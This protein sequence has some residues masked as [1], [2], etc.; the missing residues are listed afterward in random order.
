MFQ[1][2]SNIL[3]AGI[4]FFKSNFNDV[5]NVFTQHKSLMRTLLEQMLKGKLSSQ[6]FPTVDGSICDVPTKNIIVFIVGG[7][8]YQEA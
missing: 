5:Q 3:T 8:T 6:D 7:A 4:N 1:K 2:S